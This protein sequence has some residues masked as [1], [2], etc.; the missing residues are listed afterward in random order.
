M[1]IFDIETAPMDRD[2]ILAEA[3]PFDPSS[4]KLGNVKDPQLRQAKIDQAQADYYSN[5]LDRAALDARTGTVICVGLWEG[6]DIGL[7]QGDEKTVLTEFWMNVTYPGKY[8]GFNI[9]GF[10]LP[11]IVRRCWH[12]G[13]PVP[14]W[15]WDGRYFHRNFVDLMAYWQLGDRHDMI[16]LDKF[17]RFIGLEGKAR[18]GKEFAGLYASDRDAAIKYVEHDLRLTAQIARRIQA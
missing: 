10:D 18:T 15:V 2:T 3:E 7:I 8:A 9:L 13:V 16:S 17:A 14:G 5:I 12:H 11:F 4:V 6:D 1:T